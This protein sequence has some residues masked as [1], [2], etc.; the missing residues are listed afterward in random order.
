L[1]LVK[2]KM[3]LGTLTAFHLFSGLCGVVLFFEY[4]LFSELG[5]NCV[6]CDDQCFNFHLTLVITIAKAM[7]DLFTL[8]EISETSM[9]MKKKATT[10][11]IRTQ[12][13]KKLEK[14][15]TVLF[16]LYKEVDCTYK[17]SVK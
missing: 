9:V 7:V 2:Q 15:I 1:Q 11:N 17:N 3:D 14:R 13:C 8:V 10:L 16:C 5:F 12:F 4:F 6:N